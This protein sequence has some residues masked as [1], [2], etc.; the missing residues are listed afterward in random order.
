MYG[1]IGAIDETLIHACI[2]LDKQTPSRARGRGECFQNVMALCDFNMIFK[3]RNVIE[4]AFGVLKARFPI[5]KRMAPYPYGMQR[6]IVM[7]CMALHN[8][9]RNKTIDDALFSTY[10]DE[11]LDVE[12][13][14][15][16]KT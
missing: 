4:R 9:L 3:L 1:V 2:Q 11:D 16:M 12:N 13:E 7:A 5:L 8:F 14:I 6:N 15:Q 10:D